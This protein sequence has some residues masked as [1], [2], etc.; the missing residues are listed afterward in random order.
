MELGILTEDVTEH[1][2]HGCN[3]SVFFIKKRY[4][5]KKYCST[6]YAR[7]FKRRICSGCGDFASSLG[8]MNKLFVMNVLRNNPVFDVI[9]VIS[10]LVS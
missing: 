9:R 1:D 3:K 8:M 7:I 10:R 6:C 5:G 2:C 4:K